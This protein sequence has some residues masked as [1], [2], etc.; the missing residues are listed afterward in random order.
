[1]IRK[2]ITLT[3]FILASSAMVSAQDVWQAPK[4]AQQAQQTE[5]KKAS[6]EKAAQ[7]TANGKAK[8]DKVKIDPKYGEGALPIVDGKIEWQ[9]T[10]EMPGRTA[11]QAYE[12][13]MTIIDTLT[14][15]TGQ[16]DRSQI[17][18]VNPK[19][20]IIAANLVEELDFSKNALSHDF[21]L[22]RYTIICQAFDGKVDMRLCRLVYEY[23]KGRPTAA[24]YVAEEW[25]TD[26][27]CLNKSKT[28]LYPSNGKF[29]RKTIDRVEALRTYFDHA[30]RLSR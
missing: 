8:T 30:I 27:A 21:T 26:D 14:T 7:D 28:R 16:T 24:T 10:F 11:D 9:W 5:K 15:A 3:A 1:M 19:E 22:F 12:E 25:I 29:R 6:K 13:M 17:A 23:E 4:K 18:V 20:H 2:I